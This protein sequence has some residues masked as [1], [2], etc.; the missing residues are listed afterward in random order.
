LRAER[1]GKLP[2]GRREVSATLEPAALKISLY[3]RGPPVVAEGDDPGRSFLYGGMGVRY[4]LKAVLVVVVVDG[5]VAVVV[6]VVVVAE[7]DDPGRSFLYGGMGVRYGINVV[8]V[9][10]VVRGRVRVK[11]ELLG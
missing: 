4:V 11:D 5:L 6:V 9:V 7:G 3:R 1:T 10:V 2:D 8:I